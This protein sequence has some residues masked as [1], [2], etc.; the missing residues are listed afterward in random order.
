MSSSSDSEKM[1]ALLTRMSTRPKRA[2][3]ASAIRCTWASSLTSVST[4]SASRPCARIAVEGGG[5][6]VFGDAVG[7]H[8]VG[9]LSGERERDALPDPGCGTRDERDAA[10]EPVHRAAP[11]PSVTVRIVLRTASWG[12][13]VGLP[14]GVVV[15]VVVLSCFARGTAA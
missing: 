14:P 15:P 2:M 13:V 10:V 1:P 11:R 3:A 12:S 6:A 4:K 8:D 5:G 9:A 7:D